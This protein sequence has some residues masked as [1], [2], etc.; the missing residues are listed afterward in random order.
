[1][2][3]AA[4]KRAQ[5]SNENELKHSLAQIYIGISLS[6]KAVAL[7]PT[8]SDEVTKLHKLYLKRD[9]QQLTMAQ[10]CCS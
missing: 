10:V 8:K 4:T 2:L 1:M 9:H 6:Q 7:D 3:Q 5:E